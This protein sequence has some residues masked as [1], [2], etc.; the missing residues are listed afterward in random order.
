MKEIFDDFVWTKQK[1]IITRNKHKLQSL[2]NISHYSTNIAASPAPMHYH[3]DIIE[4]HC[5]VKG[6]Y[7]AFVEKNGNITEYALTGN[8]VLITYP[9]ELHSNGN[10]PIAPCEFYAFQIAIDNPSHM[11]GLNAEYSRKLVRQLMNLPNRQLQLEPASMNLVRNAFTYFSRI[12]SDSN[13][14]GCQ[15][16]NCFLFE[17]QF[18]KPITHKTVQQADERIRTAIQYLNQNIRENLQLTE[19]ADAAGYS[20]SHFKIK[21]R[22]EIGITP[23]EY[24]T[25]QKIDLAKQ[26]LIGSEASITDVAYSLGFSSSNYFCTVF[27]KIMNC[28]PSL[29][30]RNNGHSIR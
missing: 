7:N 14:I 18:L 8:Q 5:I 29:F 1:K 10:E 26:L 9:F 23:A 15:F 12:T 3:S 16:L 24:I 11:L 2:G 6:N 25:M 22:E 4:I 27:K 28:T 21:F 17:L 19:L 30:R 20:L 13:T